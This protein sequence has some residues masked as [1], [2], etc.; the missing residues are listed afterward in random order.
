M[1]AVRALT[2]P[3]RP[4]ARLVCFPHA[5]GSAN[6]FHP[7]RELV[8]ADLQLWAVQYPGRHDRIA[9]PCLEDMEAVLGDVLPELASAARLPTVLCGHSLGAAVAYEC[10]RRLPE[11]PRLLILSARRAPGRPLERELAGLSDA[12]LLAAFRELGEM[13]PALLDDPELVELVLPAL[14][15][16]CVLSESHRPG[17]HQP[18]HAPV[19]ACVGDQDPLVGAEDVRA[20]EGSTTAAFTCRVFH[21]DH[22]YLRDHAPQLIRA[23]LDACAPGGTSGAGGDHNAPARCSLPK[24]T[25]PGSTGAQKARTR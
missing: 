4:R 25:H 21:G 5:G 13:P 8:P 11:T 24:Q 9:E 15:A 16:D 14:R 6:Y 10:S 1:K 2:T 22:F 7:W 17:P 3:G 12:E 20:W 18:T 23:A 19:L